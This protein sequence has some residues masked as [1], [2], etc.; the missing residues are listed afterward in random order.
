M[1]MRAAVW[2]GWFL[3][4]VAVLLGTE[5]NIKEVASNYS[6]KNIPIP[7]WEIYCRQF[8]AKVED[9]LTRLR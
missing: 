7:S 2:W 6:A 4:H 5:P 9:F 1:M 3:M 8:I